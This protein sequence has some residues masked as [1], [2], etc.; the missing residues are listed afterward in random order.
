MMSIV[1]GNYRDVV[2]F[3]FPV[4]R[5]VGWCFLLLKMQERLFEKYIDVIR[6]RI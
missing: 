2:A 5:E 6:Q 1:N 3:C 4:R